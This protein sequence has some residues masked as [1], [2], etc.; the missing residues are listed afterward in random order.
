MTVTG[1]YSKYRSW[2]VA[3]ALEKGRVEEEARIAALVGLWDA[4]RA[5]RPEDGSFAKFARPRVEEAIDR[6]AADNR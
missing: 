6:W 1:R 5:Y 4:C 2:A 3:I